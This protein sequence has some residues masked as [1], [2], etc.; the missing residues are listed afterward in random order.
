MRQRSHCDSKVF[1]YF[2]SLKFDKAE[3]HYSLFFSLVY[4]DPGLCLS[5]FLNHPQTPTE[6]MAQCSTAITLQLS[7]PNT[8]ICLR[9]LINACAH[10]HESIHKFAINV[11][12]YSECLY[13]LFHHT[14]NPNLHT[15]QDMHI[16]ISHYFTNKHNIL[17]L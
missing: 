6:T 17:Y 16:N 7:T 13:K 8:T 1:V 15:Q 3:N 11:G 2:S 12:L 14:P 4:M 5:F 10:V 9:V